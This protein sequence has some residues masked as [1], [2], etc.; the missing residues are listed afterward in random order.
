LLQALLE[1]WGEHALVPVESQ[2]HAGPRLRRQRSWRS[3]RRFLGGLQG[4]SATGLA[5]LVEVTGGEL[6][7]LPALAVSGLADVFVDGTEPASIV[8]SGLGAVSLRAEDEGVGEGSQHGLL[9]GARRWRCFPPGCGPPQ[10]LDCLFCSPPVG[11]PFLD[12]VQRPGEVLLVPPGWAAQSADE[13]RG[14][15]LRGRLRRLQVPRRWAPPPDLPLGRT[16]ISE[17]PALSSFDTLPE[18]L[19]DAADRLVQHTFGGHFRQQ[20]E[21][22][23]AAEAR[24]DL[25]GR[26][27]PPGQPS[28]LRRVWWVNLARRRDRRAQ[29]EE[30]L[31][32]AGLWQIA[33]RVEGVDGREVDLDGVDS[34][35]AT[36]EAVA[37]AR[38]PPE[39]VVGVKL[40]R[41]ALGLLVTWHRLLSRA[42]AELQPHECALIAEDDARYAP[43][44]SHA[45]ARLMGEL[46]LYDPRWEAVQVGY[47]PATSKSL[48]LT[49]MNGLL[50]K[51]ICQ[52]LLMFGCVGVLVRGFGVA[53]LRR[54]L[55]PVREGQQL[56]SAFSGHAG[57]LRVYAS[58]VPLAAAVPS[59]CGD[60]DI[61]IL[62]AGEAESSQLMPSS[63]EVVD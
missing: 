51:L 61:Q 50:P 6:R 30:A 3:L 36:A 45:L 42:E 34:A 8:L 47:Y 13:T 27:A 33:E 11:T 23:L 29:A 48:P 57:E 41:G 12:A 22:F 31:R 58:A 37:E 1:A 2:W 46:D 55:F 38:R 7:R 63:Y 17:A 5:H 15:A 54:A 56:D 44:F 24:A 40:T 53:R 26:A 43:D 25:A 60:T 32:S 19:D 62:G 49:M 14:L 28:S 9:I 39:R 10:D 16:S 59:E 20:R 4:N 18:G 35:L 21:E 52:P